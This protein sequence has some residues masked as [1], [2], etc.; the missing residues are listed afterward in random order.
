[1]DLARRDMGLDDEL[2]ARSLRQ[3]FGWSDQPLLASELSRFFIA[4]YVGLLR[5]LM[6]LGIP[7]HDAEDALQKAAEDLVRRVREGHEIKW[8]AS[9]V[10]TAAVRFHLREQ[11]RN[12]RRLERT[13]VE[14][15]I[16]EDALDPCSVALASEDES[17][18]MELLRR[19]PSRQAEVLALAVD[20][21]TSAEIGRLLGRSPSTIRSNLMHAR[22]ALAPLLPDR[23][24]TRPTMFDGREG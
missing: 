13:P 2:D 3:R 10:K 14:S 17:Y 21:L 20:G 5:L 23:G 15:P 22:R 1:M 9:Y 24:S 6:Y 19:L 7:K 18:V 4:H 16:G 11:S 8:P 12:H